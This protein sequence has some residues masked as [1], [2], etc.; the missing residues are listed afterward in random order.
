MPVGI[1][2]S[3]QFRLLAVIVLTLILLV[4]GSYHYI[5]STQ[6]RQFVQTTEEQAKLLTHAIVK[7]FHHDMR[8]SCLK[9]IQGV[10]ERVGIL[11]DIESL[12]IFDEEG[13]VSKSKDP[14]EVGLTIEDIGYEIFKANIPSRPYRGGHGYNALCMVE[15][16]NNEKIC[17]PCH[18]TSRPIIGIFELCLSMEKTDRRIADNRRFLQL[19]AFVTVL[20]VVL[21]L[22]IFVTYWVNRPLERLATVMRKAQEGDIRVR[23]DVNR[24]DELGLV[25][26]TFN[27]ML[28]RLEE[29]RREVERYNTEQLIRA[30]RLATIGEL[31]AGVAHE[32]KN[33]LA[34]ISGAIQVLGH[35]F[36]PDDPRKAIAEQIIKQTERMDK[37]IRDLLN[38]AQPLP[39]EFTLQ[40]VN[41][42]LDTSLFIS[43]PNPATARITVV[44]D[45]EPVLPAVLFDAKHLQQ[46]FINLILNAGQ[47]MPRGGTLTLRTRV[48]NFGGNGARPAEVRVSIAD[49]GPGI[50]GEVAA[51]MFNPFFTTKTEGTG[52]GL[53]IIRRILEINHSQISYQSR[54]GEG[55][56]FFVDLPVAG[57]EGGGEP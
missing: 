4:G 39:A 46:V 5:T 43:L 20:L 55:T 28:Q 44:R 10:F 41:A 25:A 22:S 36:A 24:K 49:T 14:R 52:L 11:P 45:Y 16:I 57:Q 53:S 54:M 37:T 29:T 56:T 30:E 33:P 35:D 27:S 51:K 12:R 32:I 18:G 15:Q 1:L 9:D 3:L 31:A 26:S 38:F 40:D 48:E 42:V 34:G 47:S 19:S 13:K 8:G 2:H 6:S 7:S 23:I 21:I 17:Q 50:S